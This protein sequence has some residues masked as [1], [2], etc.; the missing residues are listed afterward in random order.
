[1]RSTAAWI[2]ACAAAASS[3][4]ASARAAKA[5]EQRLATELDA[6]RYDRPPAE[7]WQGVRRLL[8]DRGYP[9]AGADA[10][11]VGQ[12]TGVLA[13][14]LSPAK[15]THPVREE[16]GLL[17]QLGMLG[18]PA[19]VR[20]AEGSVSLDTDWSRKKGDR[21]HVDGL[22]ASDGFRVI[23]TRVQL[24]PSN[25]REARTRDL[26]LELALAQRIDPPAADRIERSVG[27]APSR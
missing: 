3:A 9:L 27:S 8:A 10:D 24:D 17:Q 13:G 21:Y 12:E 6:L 2:L 20:P 11:A 4:C 19:P 23:F 1:M 15:E 16:A 14:L 26:E 5:R 7:V 25:A 18:G 22:A